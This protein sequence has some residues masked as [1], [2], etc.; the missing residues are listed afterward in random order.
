M[1][2]LEEPILTQAATHR[3]H[4]VST[5]CLAGLVGLSMA[6]SGLV[7]AEDLPAVSPAPASP[8]K[9]PGED[10]VRSFL[11]SHCLECHSGDTP[12]GDLRLDQS[13]SDLADKT[14]TERWLKVLKQLKAGTM[15]PPK[16]TRP[17]RDEVKAVT[18][19]IAG[20]VAAADA[21]RRA[22]QGRVVLRRLNRGEYENTVRD[23]L[24]VE[25]NLK[26]LLPPD[27]AAS[28]F[29]NIGEALHTSS[30]LLERYLEAADTALN[31]AIANGPQP[32]AISKRYSLKETHQVKSTTERVFR[33]SPD[34][35]RVVLFS[36]SLW[37][38]VSLTPFYP[39]DRG[40]YRFRIRASGI[41]SSGKPVTYRVDAGLMLMTGKQ[42]LV[43]YFDAPADSPGLVEF[44]DSLEARNTIRI[45]PYGLAPAQTV[46]KTGADQFDGPGLAVDWVEVE[47]PLYD[48]WPPESHRH[49]FGDLPQAP[50]PVERDPRRLEM[51]S[52]DPLADAD[53]ILRRFVRRAFRRPA[54]DADVAPF[55]SLV[56][57]K[58]EQQQSFEQALRV[59][60]AAVMVSPD[61]LF[62]R[63]EPG[64]L[65]D[66]ALASRLSYFLWSTT[67]DEELLGL[68]ERSH[69]LDRPANADDPT[70]RVPATF[71]D[72]ELLRAQVERMLGDSKAAALTENFVGQW[73]GLREIDVTEP[74]HILYPEF[75]EML[76][77]SMVR[78]VELFFAELL[79]R[80]LSLT[81]FIASDFTMLNG[82]LAKHYGV[83]DV[84]GWEFRNV[85][86]P[87]D[88]HRGGLLTMAGVLKVT[89]N[90]TSTSPVA[91]GAWVLDRILGTPPLPPPENVAA[92]EPDIRGTTTIR[93]QLAKH[94][95][96]ESC[97]SC[98]AQIDPPGFAL[99]SFDV[100]G[101]WR[102][103]YRTSGNG[104]PVIVDGRTMHYL[105][106]PKVDPTGVLPDGRAF[107]NI[108][109]FK[110][111]LLADKDQFARALTVKLVTYATGA[112]PSV[113][114]QPQIESIV[115]KVRAQNYGFRSLIHEIV[116]SDLFRRK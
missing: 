90:G 55:I 38:S 14:Q 9:V 46:D 75:D 52:S 59:G 87:P 54:T 98:H 62:L 111:L 101:G 8:V 86:L 57:A 82:P 50:A 21:D 20:R 72:P 102:E 105:R 53:R 115:R 65:D 2:C 95:Q 73:L 39:P 24:G 13:T 42:H 34:D 49:I 80:D 106:G 113:A 96:I 56:A 33:H 1:H 84:D 7:L 17:P 103:H 22:T 36:S 15:P 108:D 47:G 26:D 83:P 19:W 100:I 44:V 85:P 4:R 99:E 110:Q 23:L 77:V 41:Q 70:H 74:S 45:L 43:S 18:D 92:L 3:V 27:T 11:T 16:K 104:Q 35:D 81:N 89:A 63:E 78:E 116:Q 28:G 76:K 32:T 107:Q 64:R 67:P 114:D 93:E 79:T 71:D 12:K 88:S 69:R 97:A 31:V 109:E 60:L 94:R 48:T 68:A 66:V 29:D 51:I 25:I 10:Q 91:R 40:R 112:A 37:Q 5:L 30:F 6:F 61:F 58:L